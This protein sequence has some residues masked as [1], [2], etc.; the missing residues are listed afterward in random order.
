MSAT[1]EQPKPTAK[2][3]GLKKA[4]KQ[5]KSPSQ[6]GPLRQALA[7]VPLTTRIYLG[8]GLLVVVVAAV[9]GVSYL[10][11]DK[12]IRG[13]DTAR[14]TQAL[15]V[16]FDES[17]L[18][19]DQ[20]ILASGNA[21]QETI[22]AEAEHVRAEIDAVQG[23]VDQM[24]DTLGENTELTAIA[25]AVSAYRQAFDDYSALTAANAEAI[26]SAASAA[27]DAVSTA[28]SLMSS[29]WLIY[30]AQQNETQRADF[31]LTQALTMAAQANE[32]LDLMQQTR[33]HESAF[34]LTGDRAEYDLAIES[35]TALTAAAEAMRDA[36]S[37]EA[38]EARKQAISVVVSAKG[39]EST[40]EALSG[41]LLVQAYSPEEPLARDLNDIAAD[42]TGAVGALRDLQSTRLSELQELTTQH[43]EA[44]NAMLRVVRDVSS[45]L[46]KISDARTLERDLAATRDAR[47]L[48]G[49]KAIL[50]S[51]TNLAT[52]LATDIS[53]EAVREQLTSLLTGI[54]GF[55]SAADL[56]ATNMEQQEAAATA[57]DEAATLL[58][59][60]VDA[61]ANQERAAMVASKDLAIIVI[62]VAVAAAVLLA[63][64]TAVALGRAIGR[65]INRIVADMGKLS[66]GDLQT[67]I[68]GVGR[69]D[70]IGKIA[71]ALQV[72][73][74]T[75]IEAETANKAREADAEAARKRASH[76]ASTTEAF[77]TRINAVLQQL[78]S[79]GDTLRGTANA[80]S[81]IASETNDKASA[82]SDLSAQ[83]SSNVDMV[84]AATEELSASI[85]EVSVQI[86]HTST[87]ADNAK[88]E[89]SRASGTINELHDGAAKVGEVVKIISEIAEQTNLLALN[90][91]IEAARAGEA[92]RGFAVVASEV[93]A[94]AEQ[95]AR[96]TDDISTQIAQIQR[97]IVEAVPVIES[98]ASTIESL[99]TTSIQV[100]SSAEEQ[101]ATTR[102]ISANAAKAAT[103]TRGVTEQMTTMVEAANRA[104]ASAAE[105]LQAAGDLTEAG[106]V[107]QREIDDYVNEIA[108]A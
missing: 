16:H 107:L 67:E 25:T 86:A 24:A 82:A 102:D 11:L 47:K 19:Q 78:T 38:D 34:L 9:G 61:L 49:I 101:N 104:S 100:A 14:E 97:Q 53:D 20:F 21:D 90:A 36:I 50:A 57:M 12:L 6:P 8:F 88:T 64:L 23:R 48:R 103:N 39:Y 22:A 106:S 58:R 68:Q 93:K 84:A 83:T 17:L 65:P 32:I 73:K 63:V 7:A 1:L 13:A 27:T 45:I 56:L 89:A 41:R 42:L 33:T 96:A 91:T 72:F 60:N 74:E 59:S 37:D 76:M 35:V 95:T 43:R 40:L 69:K 85:Q 28:G 79:A 55:Q 81:G 30:S 10:S 70:E 108:A 98:V 15:V 31:E 3:V 66:A 94:L 4:V 5:R 54:D 52:S 99:A 77:T 46:A 80:M 51:A 87:Q 105:V 26:A 92:G 75:A 2:K 29:R 62:G 44:S 18:A 71:A